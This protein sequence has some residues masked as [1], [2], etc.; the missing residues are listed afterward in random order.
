MNEEMSIQKKTFQKDCISET[1][2]VQACYDQCCCRRRPARTQ[3]LRHPQIR[4][5]PQQATAP[6]ERRQQASLGPQSCIPS[7]TPRRQSTSHRND[8]AKPQR[9]KLVL[10]S[11]SQCRIPYH[12]TSDHTITTAQSNMCTAQ[13]PLSQNKRPQCNH[14]TS[15]PAQSN[16]SDA[17]A[18]ARNSHG[19]VALA[20]AAIA[21]LPE[22]YFPR[23]F[24]RFGFG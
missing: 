7:T 12:T 17:T 8:P 11:S 2:T 3:I 18:Q 20:R 9:H 14:N 15:Y 6:S 13:A 19:R 23:D 10:I 21:V 22:N 24:V 1:K 16:H 5:T 4:L